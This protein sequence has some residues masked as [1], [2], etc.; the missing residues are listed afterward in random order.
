[1]MAYIYICSSLSFGPSDFLIRRFFFVKRW[2]KVEVQDLLFS[3]TQE[4][5]GSA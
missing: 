2:L 3:F 1:M 5:S 4:Y